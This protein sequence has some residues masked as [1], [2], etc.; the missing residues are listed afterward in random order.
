M[1]DIRIVV[2]ILCMMLSFVYSFAQSSDQRGKGML[3]YEPAP[4]NPAADMWCYKKDNVWYVYTLDGHGQNSIGVAESPDLIM[5]FRRGIAIPNNPGTW[6]NSLYGGDV[7]KWKDKYYMLYSAPGPE[8]N[9]AI[10]L[11]ESQDMI[12]WMKHPRNPVM[13][14]PD[15][16]W[17][18]GTTPDGMRGGTSCRDITVIEDASTDEWVYCCFTA[19]TGRG[20]YYR[21]G[22]IGL[23][24]SRNLIDWEYLPP[25]FSPSIYTAME[26]PRICK[27][28]DRWFLTWLHA[29]WYG[30]RT[31]EDFG[32]LARHWGETMIHYAVAD[33]PLG[34]YHLPEDPTLFRGYISPYVI[35]LVHDGE[36]I[37]VTTTMFKQ[38][39]EDFDD[40]VRCGLMPAM[41]IRQ[42]ANNKEKL[43]V[44][45]PDKIRNYFEIKV[46]I[47]DRLRV[48]NPL[49]GFQEVEKKGSNFSFTKTSNRVAELT[50]AIN[51]DLIIDINYNVQSGR[52]GL[53]TRMDEKSRSGCIILIDQAKN[54][55][56]FAEL[57]PI[58]EKGIIVK[59]L[60]RFNIDFLNRPEK[61]FK[62]TVIQSADYTLAFMDNVFVGSFS[63]ACRQAG[64]VG[65]FL[66]NATGRAFVE[67]L[68]TREPEK[69]RTTM[70]N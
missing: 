52:A 20:D 42:A 65:L 61:D 12:T 70:T 6:E 25:L 4:D 49:A 18:D 19:S 43:Q 67:S 66:E 23:A 5:Y 26:V 7:F 40:R 53:I 27:I 16:R 24:R 11:A 28:G 60:E 14:H 55:L 64:S 10:G 21:R 59:T 57:A 39:G 34:P 41:P 47:S 8:F 33:N 3:F 17:Y 2:S 54:E 35:D 68:F 15:A 36:E 38:G 46:P 45:F 51:G 29:P 9:N 58:Y 1:K 31:D 69:V 62:L 56:Q 44:Y 50:E 22:C 32:Q 48:N 30:I 37:V 63:F 13:L